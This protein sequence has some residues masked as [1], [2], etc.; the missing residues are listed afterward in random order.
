MAITGV[1]GTGAI[2][3]KNKVTNEKN[4]F[5]LAFLI[6]VLLSNSSNRLF[7]QC[8]LYIA[9]VKAKNHL[10]LINTTNIPIKQPGEIGPNPIIAKTEKT[11]K[12]LI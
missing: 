9:N 1:T 12:H 3:I 8:V 7:P 10:G 2:S 4:A 5:I 11:L 6:Y